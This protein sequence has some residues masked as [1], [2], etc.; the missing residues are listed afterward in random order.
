[1]KKLLA[2]ILA[3]VLMLSASLALA[4]DAALANA[5]DTHSFP[6]V[7]IGSDWHEA[8]EAFN[9]GWK[10]SGQYSYSD[11]PE[12]ETITLSDGTSIAVM[13]LPAEKTDN[14]MAVPTTVKL[15]F[16]DNK[17]VAAVQFADVPEGYDPARFA[18]NMADV[19]GSAPVALDTSK[20]SARALEL[21]RETAHLED[22]VNAWPYDLA[23]NV[24]GNP[25][26]VNVMCVTHIVN[27]TLYIAE[28][29]YKKAESN[30]VG[31]QNLA[32]IEG[33]DK[34]SAEEQSAVR[35][36]AEFLQK[37]QSEL[38]KQYVDFLQTKHQ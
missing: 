4:E 34:L 27:N 8:L 24:D 1:M 11:T 3:V 12:N 31:G 13:T 9:A 22:G 17:L 2:L 19:M 14:T 32:K 30:T 38:L 23:V 26:V 29:A 18:E 10:G 28:L 5:R 15:Y 21:L 36:Y 25:S 7:A 16:M 35:L 20:L 6:Y 33:F 37:Q